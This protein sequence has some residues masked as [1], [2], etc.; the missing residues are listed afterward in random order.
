MA[1]IVKGESFKVAFTVKDIDNGVTITPEMV[2]GVR[3]ALGSQIATYP[4]G[5]L[6][7]STED[8]TWRFPMSQ[9]NT[10]SAVGKT[11]DYQVQVKIGE[12]VFSTD[13]TPVTLEETMFRKEWT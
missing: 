13:I 10:L 7:F 6:T 1:K 3:I 4:D 8:N 12:D 2:D 9:K 11:F 5:S